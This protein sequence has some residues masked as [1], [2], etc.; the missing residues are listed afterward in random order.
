ML[1]T[2]NVEVAVTVSQ[3]NLQFC[4]QSENIYII[5]CDPIISVYFSLFYIKYLIFQQWMYE[6]TGFRQAVKT[7]MQME[8]V[9]Y[10]ITVKLLVERGQSVQYNNLKLRC[11][12]HASWV[13]A[14]TSKRVFL[15]VSLT[16]IVILIAWNKLCCLQVS[17][18][19]M[20]V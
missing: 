11:F 2:L 7:T 1:F 13:V 20:L 15:L 16:L 17:H 14:L 6:H 9:L 5:I 19:T 4:V 10:H 8:W 18:K 12:N 3:V